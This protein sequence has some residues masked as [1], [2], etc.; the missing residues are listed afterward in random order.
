MIR[1]GALVLLSVAAAPCF[2]MAQDER[3]WGPVLRVTPSVAYGLTFRQ[4][5]NAEI[6]AAN[7]FL[8]HAYHLD[9]AASVPLGLTVDVRF[10]DRF[11]IVAGGAWSVRGSAQITDLDDNITRPAG[12]SD[13]LLAKLGLGVRLSEEESEMRLYQLSG[14]FF[15]APAIIRETGKDAAYVRTSTTS[16]T[17]HFGLNLGTEGELPLSNRHFALTIGVEDWIIF[18]NDEKYRKRIASYLETPSRGSVTAID[19][20]T[21]HL[22]LI[23][24][25]ITFRF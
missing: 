24:T 6:V 2:A 12:G 23:R 25:G 15:V 11:S 1:C 18:W 22:L 4:A 13:L 21:S 3:N 20:G 8:V 17:Q 9:Y 16:N 7:H 19:A 14:S 10:W 5:G